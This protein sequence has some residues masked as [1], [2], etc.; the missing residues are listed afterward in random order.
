MLL[1]NVLISRCVTRR[2]FLCSAL[3]TIAHQT[4]HHAQPRHTV[5]RSSTSSPARTRRRSTPCSRSIAAAS[6]V[7]FSRCSHRRHALSTRSL[8]VLSRSIAV[9]T[10]SDPSLLPPPLRSLFFHLYCRHCYRLTIRYYHC[11]YC[12]LSRLSSA[13]WLSARFVQ[14]R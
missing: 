13:A 8:D 10:S 14:S 6:R 12:Y 9:A 11:Y 2:F 1:L 5:E 4:N 7:A 3:A